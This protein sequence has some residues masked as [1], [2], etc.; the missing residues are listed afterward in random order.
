MIDLIIKKE[1][2]SVYWKEYFNSLDE[3]NKWLEIEKTRPYYDPKYTEEIID[4]TPPPKSEADI[5]KEEADK[6][7]KE[8][9]KDLIK[10]LKKSDLS[11]VS[12][13]ADAILN[14][15]KLLNLDK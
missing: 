4:N 3:C 8:S 6:L 9:L 5:A 11:T 14:L 15:I 1:D 7:A 13:C 2:G 12:A 10:K